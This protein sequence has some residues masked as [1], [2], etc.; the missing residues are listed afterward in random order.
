[1]N[2]GVS[3][4]IEVYIEGD[5]A[6]AD[7]FSEVGRRFIMQVLA[8]GMRSAAGPY[9]LGVKRITPLEGSDADDDADD[10]TDAGQDTGFIASWGGG[11]GAAGAS[12]TGGAPGASGTGG[13]GSAP[14]AS[15]T[16]GSHVV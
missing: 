12:G 10:S 7:D 8:A 2:K 11:T 14:G 16:G 1:M 5:A 13:A 4:Q 9:R 15:G 3:L 6:P